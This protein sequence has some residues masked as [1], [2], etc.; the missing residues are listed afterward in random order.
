V[1]G[2][3]QRYDGVIPP[4]KFE[5]WS[6]HSAGMHQFA[7]WCAF[8]A[9]GMGANLQHYNPNIDQ[10]VRD[11]WGVSQDWALKAQLVFGTPVSHDRKEKQLKPLE[12]R[13][14]V[15]GI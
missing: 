14:L 9:D 7:W 10:M 13:V 2:L 3:V 6:E 4:E 15:K 8:E 5:Q 12:E 1:A 11:T